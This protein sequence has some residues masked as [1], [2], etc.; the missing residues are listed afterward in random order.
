LDCLVI[1]A[2][3]QYAKPAFQLYDQALQRTNSIPDFSLHI[4]DSYVQ[5]ILG[6]RS[7]GITSILL[8][9]HCRFDA[10]KLDCPVVHSLLE[11]VDLLGITDLPQ[12]QD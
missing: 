8:D 3:L 12:L 2:T 11:L 6:A 1:S 5:D 10:E 7:V 4:G 9:R